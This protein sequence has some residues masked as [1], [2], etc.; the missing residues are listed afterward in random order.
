[1]QQKFP[2]PHRLMIHNIAVRVLA[3]VR[4]HQPSFISRNFAEGFL[5]LDLPVLGRL[6]LGSGQ[7]HTG[8]ETIGKE[9]IVAGGPVIAQDLDF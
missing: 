4:I 3:D 6:D 7:N 9:V 2:A 5:E 8:F 1:M